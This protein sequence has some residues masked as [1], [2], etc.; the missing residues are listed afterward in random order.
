MYVMKNKRECQQGVSSIL[1]GQQRWNH[2]KQRLCGHEGPTTDWCWR[3]VENVPGCGRY[4]L[5]SFSNLDQSRFVRR[6]RSSPVKK[7]AQIFLV[8][9]GMVR[10]KPSPLLKLNRICWRP[11]ALMCVAKS[12]FSQM[13]WSRSDLI[14]NA[15][16]FARI[17]LDWS[18]FD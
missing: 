11:A 17:D 13:H 18:R 1:R 5:C 6:D 12:D 16:H 14:S 10:R 4:L 3:S 2:E 8:V 7:N 15:K 9:V